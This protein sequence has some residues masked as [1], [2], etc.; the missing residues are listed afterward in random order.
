MIDVLGIVNDNMLD[1][2][3]D[4]I[5][6]DLT[7]ADRLGHR[8]AHSCTPISSD[9]TAIAPNCMLDTTCNAQKA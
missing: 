1:T 5:A 8:Y 3:A 6:D 7:Y 9:G 4:H 2:T